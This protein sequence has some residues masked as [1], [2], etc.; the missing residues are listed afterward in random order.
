MASTGILQAVD[1]SMDKGASGSDSVKLSFN[2]V[3]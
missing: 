3:R 1:S 2:C